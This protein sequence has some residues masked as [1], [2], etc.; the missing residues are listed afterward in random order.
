MQRKSRNA[1]DIRSDNFSEELYFS[2]LGDDKIEQN[3]LEDSD[4]KKET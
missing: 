3:I 4:E 1:S 2:D